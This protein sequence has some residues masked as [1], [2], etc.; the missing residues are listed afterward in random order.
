MD[1]EIIKRFDPKNRSH[2]RWLRDIDDIM[3]SS[4]HD[5]VIPHF[6]R[7]PMKVQPKDMETVAMDWIMWHFGLCVKF[8]QSIFALDAWIPNYNLTT[9]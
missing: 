9:K 2:V 7:N 5:E 3:K 8:T 6:M 4:K 1:S